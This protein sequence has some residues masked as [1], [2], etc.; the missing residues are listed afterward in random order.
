MLV[1][2]LATAARCAHYFLFFLRKAAKSAASIFI[3]FPPFPAIFFCLGDSFLETVLLGVFL[4]I[5]PHVAHILLLTLLC[6]ARLAS[7]AST[8]FSFSLSLAFSKARC[9]FFLTTTAC[10]AHYFFFFLA[11]AILST[12]FG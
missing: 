5:H 2:W 12:R 9:S 3:G 6:F 10:Y 8:Y 7:T 1:L 11:A 4:P